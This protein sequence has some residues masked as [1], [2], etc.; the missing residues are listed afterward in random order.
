V[1]IEPRAPSQFESEIQGDPKGEHG[2]I[3]ERDPSLLL[4]AHHLARQGGARIFTIAALS[5]E[6]KA[7]FQSAQSDFEEGNG[8]QRENGLHG[9]KSMIEQ[10]LG[11]QF[12]DTSLASCTFITSVPFNIYPFRYPTGH[13]PPQHAAEVITAGFLKSTIHQLHTGI[14]IV[15]DSART[16]SSTA[17]EFEAISTSLGQHG[18]SR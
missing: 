14:A 6:E 13:V 10:K 4:I 5:Q 7:I 16:Q 9:C 3:V 15:L 2:I 1:R 12:L 18:G 17:S 11:P 8:L